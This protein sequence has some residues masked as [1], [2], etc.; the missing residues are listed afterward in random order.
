MGDPKINQEQRAEP[1]KPARWA[2]WLELSAMA[3]MGQKQ[4]GWAIWTLE[5]WES[6]AAQC[7][8]FDPDRRMAEKAREWARHWQQRRDWIDGA[9]SAQPDPVLVSIR[10]AQDEWMRQARSW[11]RQAQIHPRALVPVDWMSAVPQQRRMGWKGL[12]AQAREIQLRDGSFEEQWSRLIG[13]CAPTWAIQ[14]EPGQDER[15]ESQPGWIAIM[16]R[17][18]LLGVEGSALEKEPAIVKAARL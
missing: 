9:S 5:D 4:K 17:E 2:L 18:Q 6:R 12:G 3:P 7:H 14:S 16:E 8:P 15:L 1:R 11:L 10:K 13:V